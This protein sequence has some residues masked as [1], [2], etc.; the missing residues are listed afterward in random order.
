MLLYYRGNIKNQKFAI[1]MQVK[2]F[3]CDFLSSI[4]QIKQMPNVVK[5]TAKINTM[6]N[7]NSLLFGRS[8]S[9]TSLKL[10]S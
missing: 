8:L 6:Q 4:H 5:I 7:I 1:L 9:L 10:C 3:K 2:R